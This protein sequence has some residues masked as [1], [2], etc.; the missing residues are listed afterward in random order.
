MQSQNTQ[1]TRTDATAADTIC[2]NML[3][4]LQDD[5]K[6]QLGQLHSDFGV[7]AGTNN[8]M[9]CPASHMPDA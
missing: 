8:P 4:F 6:R 1:K 2:W 5:F 9:S 3:L 7:A